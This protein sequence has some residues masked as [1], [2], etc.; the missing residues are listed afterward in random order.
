MALVVCPLMALTSFFES[1]MN[2]IRHKEARAAESLLGLLSSAA[3]QHVAFAER[4]VTARRLERDCGG[5]NTGEMV[6]IAADDDDRSDLCQSATEGGE[7]DRRER[8]A[9]VPEKRAD[10]FPPG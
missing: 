7:A 6:D 1:M 4:Q 10:A 9:C 2:L 3:V 8:I 5:H